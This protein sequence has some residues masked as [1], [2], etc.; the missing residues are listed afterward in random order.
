[1][2]IQF[3]NEEYA[4]M[5]F[6]YGMCKGNSAAAA[7]EYVLRYP[8]RRHPCDK[9]ITRVY[10]TL[11]ETGS[12]PKIICDR[13]AARRDRAK[14][15][16]LEIDNDPRISLRKLSAS[17]GQSRSSIHRKLQENGFYPYHIQRVQSLLPLDY[18]QRLIFC[19]WLLQ[20]VNVIPITLFCDEATFSR[21]GIN[22]Y[23]NDHV[24]DTEN[25]HAVSVTHFQHRFS[26]N[27][28]GGLLGRGLH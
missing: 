24:W 20:N 3:S 12:F 11:R 9:T 22:N 25:P 18:G 19:N 23:H 1:M 14:D 21:D 7:R 4:D 6:M 16:L 17:T 27:V 15:V 2:P 5:V 13:E 8:N 28:W 10:S 26:V